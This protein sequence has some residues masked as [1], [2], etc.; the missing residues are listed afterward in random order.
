LQ[1]TLARLEPAKAEQG[2]N[3]V[4]R[5]TRKREPNEEVPQHVSNKRKRT[6]LASIS[7]DAKSKTF[8]TIPSHVKVDLFNSIVK[9]AFPNF[10]NLMVASWNVVSIYQACG[11]DFPELHRSI[12]ELRGVLQDFDEATGERA[13][14]T[15]LN[16]RHD[17]G[18][19]SQNGGKGDRQNGT[20]IND[21]HL[22]GD[23]PNGGRIN[24]DRLIAPA[25]THTQNG[26]DVASQAN[27]SAANE[28]QTEPVQQ[29]D[30]H[31]VAADLFGD[32]EDR[33]EPEMPP[34]RTMQLTQPQ[35]KEDNDD[36]DDEVPAVDPR[37]HRLDR[38]S[39]TRQSSTHQPSPSYMAGTHMDGSVPTSSETSPE[40]QQTPLPSD[41]VKKVRDQNAESGVEEHDGATAHAQETSPELLRRC[42]EYHA[43][44][45]GKASA[46][47][48]L[49][50]AT[51]VQSSR[52][53]DTDS[54]SERDRPA[55]PLHDQPTPTP[56]SNPKP[57]STQRK[58]KMSD[59]TTEQIKTRL[60]ELK[61]KLLRT[62]ITMDQ[63]PEAKMGAINQFQAALDARE[64]R[65]RERERE[66]EAEREQEKEKDDN[67]RRGGS[68]TGNGMFGTYLGN[69]MLGAKKPMGVAPVAPMF[70]MGHKRD[71]YMASDR[72]ERN[73]RNGGASPPNG[74]RGH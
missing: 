19:P 18:G 50:A 14:R 15:A 47:A 46:L 35:Q 52:A 74:R 26:A 29:Q 5:R 57:K 71:G 34:P 7:E 54:H 3:Q 68:G 30:E 45:I 32:D 31:D 33:T 61:A 49:R 59:L 21:G 38:Q 10:D 22:N 55:P 60:E 9:T 69:S 20:R 24:E 37:K 51:P 39:S 13:D 58:K 36:D 27:D 6:G 2:H 65:A 42:E 41:C 48:N 23:L 44:S 25:P 11:S 64:K 40:P 73:G 62:F 66:R 67:S 28:N 17:F 43:S 53:D 12:V 56:S 16:Y 72:G 4:A 70:P 1:Q 63:I 8:D